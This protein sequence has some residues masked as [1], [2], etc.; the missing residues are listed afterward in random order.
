[1]RAWART[2]SDETVVVYGVAGTE[3][4]YRLVLRTRE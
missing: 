2:L 1:M 4:E 3:V